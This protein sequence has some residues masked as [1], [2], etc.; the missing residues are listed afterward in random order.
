MA[1]RA[2][3]I[4]IVEARF[5]DDIA[6]IATYLKSTT[7]PQPPPQGAPRPED[8]ARGRGIY[9][10]YCASC[11]AGNGAPTPG[12]AKASQR[13]PTPT[14]GTTSGPMTASA[15]ASAEHEP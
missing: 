10:A 11:H 14:F 12:T 6:A 4:L 13:R 15:A 7:S 9:G 3:H 1:D 5:Y 2:P 8:M